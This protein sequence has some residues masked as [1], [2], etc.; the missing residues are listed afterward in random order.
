MDWR[1]ETLV[2]SP[3]NASL[4]LNGE[5][6]PAEEGVDGEPEDRF[7]CKAE[8]DAKSEVRDTLGE[9]LGAVDRVANPHPVIGPGAGGLFFGEDDVGRE[10]LAENGRDKP[11]D[12]HIGLRND[13]LVALGG[14]GDPAKR[15]TDLF[16]RTFGAGTGNG[17]GVAAG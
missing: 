1:E 17:D 8:R 11:F 15:G 9:V 7:A 2:G 5:H 6:F 13:V 12:C 3:L 4:P 14:N 16:D 10:F